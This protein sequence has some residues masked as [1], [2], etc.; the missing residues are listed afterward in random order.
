M[1]RRQLARRAF[2]PQHKRLMFAAHDAPGGQKVKA[3]KTLQA[4][5]TACLASL[6]RPARPAGRGRRRR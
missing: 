1:T 3:G 2:D 6:P 5:V 4:Y